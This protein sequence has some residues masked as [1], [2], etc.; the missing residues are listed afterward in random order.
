[1]CFFRPVPEPPYW[2]PR[3]TF[4][5]RLGSNRVPTWCPLG[6]KICPKS[7]LAPLSGVDRASCFLGH[8]WVRTL[9]RNALET[10]LVQNRPCR[11]WSPSGPMG[12]PWGSAGCPKGTHGSRKGGLGE[13]P[14]G[15][16]HHKSSQTRPISTEMGALGAR[17]EPTGAKK[18]P[19]VLGWGFGPRKSRER[20]D[21]CSQKAAT[22]ARV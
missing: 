14:G 9:S 19:M 20:D 2:C 5:A 10:G 15:K 8:F 16:R 6:T 18:P 12:C 1:M 21:K 17:N 4:L 13:S 11:P 3:T 7:F 22:V